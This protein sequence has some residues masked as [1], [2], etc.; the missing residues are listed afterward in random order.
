M[1]GAY[2]S[3]D[4]KFLVPEK[5]CIRMHD[6][7][8]I[9]VR[10]SGTSS[11]SENLGRVTLVCH[12]P[13]NSCCNNSQQLTFGALSQSTT[14]KNL[15]IF[16]SSSNNSN[17]YFNQSL[18]CTDTVCWPRKCCWLVV[19]TTT[20]EKFIVQDSWTYI[21]VLLVWVNAGKAWHQKWYP[22]KISSMHEK[23]RLGYVQV[24]KTGSIWC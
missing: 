4:S 6:T 19:Y 10:D 5:S 15:L 2:E 17:A 24:L 21:R 18:F 13:K 14:L 8:A 22:A 16:I 11:S 1:R 12:G 23:D 3:R 9:L 7:R 20:W